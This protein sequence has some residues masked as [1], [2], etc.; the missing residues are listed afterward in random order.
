KKRIRIVA[1]SG[2]SNVLG[3]FN[4][5]KEIG[6]IVHQ[7]GARLLVDA[8]QMI[9]HRKVDMERCGI[10]YLAFSA[11][12]VYAPFG[13]GVLVARKGLLHFTLVKME[14][15]QSSGEENTVGIAS[16]GKALL[17]LQRIGPDIIREEEQSLTERALR[18]LSQIEGLTIYGIKD[19]GAHKFPLKGGVIV[20]SLKNK[21]SNVV[22]KELAEQGGI[23]VRY[24]CH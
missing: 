3:V 19:P 5:L 21:F 18:G 15:I 14:M 1:V 17:L 8:A 20:F 12:K 24:G 22:A 9:A 11:H 16:L 4:D 2:A 10:D 13:T 23:G 6:R 7:Y